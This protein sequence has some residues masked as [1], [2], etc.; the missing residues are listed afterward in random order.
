MSWLAGQL[1]LVAVGALPQVAFPP[2]SLRLPLLISL[3]AQDTADTEEQVLQLPAHWG[4]LDAI[5]P[6]FQC[7]SR[8]SLAALRCRTSAGPAAQ[9]RYDSSQVFN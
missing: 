5:D 3:H 2:S 9:T 1:E 4:R 6:A 7:L 8:L